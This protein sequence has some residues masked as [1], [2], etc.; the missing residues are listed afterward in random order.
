[1]KLIFINIF[2]VSLDKVRLLEPL[3]FQFIDATLG[4]HNLNKKAHRCG[5]FFPLRL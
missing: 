3:W 1:M 5:H 2:F 4:V